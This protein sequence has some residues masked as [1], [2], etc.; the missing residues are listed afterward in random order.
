MIASGCTSS[1]SPRPFL[2]RRGWM[3]RGS[4]VSDVASG[5]QEAWPPRPGR[6]RSPVKARHGREKTGTGGCGSHR[7]GARGESRCAAAG[8]RGCP[9]WYRRPEIAQ[10]GLHFPC[11]APGSLP[12]TSLLWPSPRRP[13][14]AGPHPSGKLSSCPAPTSCRNH[15]S[16]SFRPAAAFTGDR[17]RP[18]RAGHVSRPPGAPSLARY[19]HQNPACRPRYQRQHQSDHKMRLGQLGMWA[20]ARR[21]GFSF[22]S[23]IC[24]LQSHAL[25]QAAGRRRSSS[26]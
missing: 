5:G 20:A 3:G 14:A 22:A 9:P 16:R 11:R 12:L 17:A 4:R 24:P 13:A 15:P 21:A 7:A 2:A 23:W 25:N 19:R 1:V 18:G 6:A 10:P 26:P 8:R